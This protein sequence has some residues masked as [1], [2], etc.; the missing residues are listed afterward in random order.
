MSNNE[1]NCVFPWGNNKR[2][3]TYAEYYGRIYGGRVQ[4]VS[5]DAGFTCPNRD[6]TL[7]KGGCTYCDNNSFNPSYCIPRKSVTEQIAE[8]VEFHSRRYRRAGKFLAYFQ[9]YSNTYANIERLKKLYSEA[10]AYPGV[11]GLVIGTRPD[12]VDGRI[13]DYLAELSKTYHIVLEYGVESCYD[14]T[15]KRINRQHDFDCSRR[16]IENAAEKGITTGAHL[17]FGLPG[18]SIKD[19]LDEVD[20]MSALPIRS[21]KFHQL[22]LIKNTKIVEEYRLN[23][24]DF[25]VF[26]VE[27]YLDFMIEVVEKLRHDIVVERIAGEVP[28]KFLAVPAWSYLRYDRLLALFEK[29]LEDCNTWQGRKC[30]CD[31]PADS[32]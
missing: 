24:S 4:K 27:E 31:H 15:L 14:R 29:K 3:N 32:F 25:H 7:G 6:G 17:I 10:L 2:F 22:Q 8:G 26:D 16:A 28:P 19:M 23:P 12:C 13:L 20:I 1:M 5:I 11:I 9:A 30:V 18:E 21:I